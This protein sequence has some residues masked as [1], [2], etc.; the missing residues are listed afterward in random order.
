M[1]PRNRARAISDLRDKSP[2]PPFGSPAVLPPK[3]L[4]NRN[5][6]RKPKR[7]SRASCPQ[8]LISVAQS[9]QAPQ[10]PSLMSLRVSAPPSFI[11]HAA[12][13]LSHGR[14]PA[15]TIA[16]ELASAQSHLTAVRKKPRTTV[17][18]SNADEDSQRK[19]TPYGGYCTSIAAVRNGR[20]GCSR[21]REELQQPPPQPASALADS[22]VENVAPASVSLNISAAAVTPEG[23][24]IRE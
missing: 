1:A 19:S 2:L 11:V 5:A 15:T 3:P 23:G 13:P 21:G 9:T 18:I 20:D 22:A 24:V 14:T 8:L 12:P 7:I 17:R 4:R 16:E 6:R 10:P